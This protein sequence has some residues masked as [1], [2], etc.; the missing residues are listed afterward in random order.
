MDILVAAYDINIFLTNAYTRD[1]MFTFD[2]L[3]YVTDLVCVLSKL[4]FNSF[5]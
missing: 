4:P 2:L 1:D 5:S 3:L